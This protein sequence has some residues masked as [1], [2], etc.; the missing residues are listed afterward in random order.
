MKKFLPIM[1]SVFVIMFNVLSANASG[2]VLRGVDVKR[3][4]DSYTIE[5]TSTEPARVNKTIVS[6]NRILINLKNVNVSS[7]LTTKFNGNS[8]IDNVMVEPC[9]MDSVN[10]MVQG[11]NVALSNIVFKAPSFVE[12]TEDMVK[13]SF[14]SLFS[15]FSGSSKTD[16][17]VQYGTLLLFLAIL[18]GEISFIKSKISELKAEKQQM[19]KDIERTKNFQDYLPGYGSAGVKKPYTTPIYGTGLST[20]S[21]NKSVIRPFPTSD[22]LTVNAILKNKSANPTMLNKIIGNPPS[23]GSLAVNDT[24]HSR[25]NMSDPFEKIRLNA[26]LKY[27]EEQTKRYKSAATVMDLQNEHRTRLNKIY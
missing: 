25:Q 22:N 27:L 5:L 17:T 19:L 24:V 2:N 18:F 3:G 1:I 14:T 13:G 7:N 26:H 20:V 9:G 21:T 15:I 10:V 12:N 6:S 11:D 8:V 16:K 23:F 4:A